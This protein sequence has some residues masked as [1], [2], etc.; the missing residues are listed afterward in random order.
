[1]VTAVV[2]LVLAVVEVPRLEPEVADPVFVNQVTAKDVARGPKR[3]EVRLIVT[4]PADATAADQ[5][6]HVNAQLHQSRVMLTLDWPL[7]SEGYPPVARNFR[8]WKTAALTLPDDVL[9]VTRCDYDTYVNTTLLRG[10]LAGLDPHHRWLVGVVSTGR[11]QD[12]LS[13]SK[14]VMGGGCET[15]SVGLLRAVEVAKCEAQS[16]VEGVRNSDVAWSKC[17]VRAGAKIVPIRAGYLFGYKKLPNSSAL[18]SLPGCK[19]PGPQT[20]VAHPYKSAHTLAIASAA[21][22]EVLTAA[23]NC[24]CT[25]SPV[26]AYV[27]TSCDQGTSYEPGDSC[28]SV[29]AT[30]DA[31]E[32]PMRLP[33]S[34]HIVGFN[35]AARV[36]DV[37]RCLTGTIHVHRP[38]PKPRKQVLVT[39]GEA[40]LLRTMRR[41]LKQAAV[42]RAPFVVLEDDFIVHQDACERWK[43][44]QPCYWDAMRHGGI[45]LFGHTTWRPEAWWPEQGGEAVWKL[46]IPQCLQGTQDT[47]GTFAVAYSPQAAEAAAEWIAATLE[48]KPYDHMYPDLMNVN[49]P[50]RMMWPP[51]IVADV[52]HVSMVNNNKP[53]KQNVSFRHQQHKWGPRSEYLPPIDPVY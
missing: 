18:A 31:F 45:F 2:P 52:G 16:Q 32:A 22:K 29:P 6:A 36:N 4:L 24:S 42:S 27:S 48:L 28:A 17:A 51:A 39:G 15:V 10:V 7:A 13:I 12:R 14:Y 30:C 3:T 34:I 11:P 53:I 35:A 40:S 25:R 26:H 44:A 43:A 21:Q 47:L 41:V 49:R 8:V 1:M 46:N 50:V 9:W 38:A 5:Y 20:L 33:H 23:A 37:P 19:L